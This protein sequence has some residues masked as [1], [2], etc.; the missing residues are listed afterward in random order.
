[1]F[2]AVPVPVPVPESEFG[3]PSSVEDIAGRDRSSALRAHFGLRAVVV[4]APGDPAGVVVFLVEQSI[5]LESE[6]GF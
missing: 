1:M 3:P 2:L 5:E 6:D 4:V